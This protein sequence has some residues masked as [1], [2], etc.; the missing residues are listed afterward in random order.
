MTAWRS[1]STWLYVSTVWAIV[2]CP[3]WLFFLYVNECM[4]AVWGVNF[5][6]QTV[7]SACRYSPSATGSEPSANDLT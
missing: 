1:G 4:T 6:L 2:T 5:L 3:S 7:F